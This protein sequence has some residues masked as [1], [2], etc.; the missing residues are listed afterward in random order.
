MD[1]LFV[2]MRNPSPQTDGDAM[3]Q[4]YRLSIG[5]D[6]HHF[7][8][9]LGQSQMK[10]TTDG[11]KCKRSMQYHVTTRS[12]IFVYRIYSAMTSLITLIHTIVQAIHVDYAH[13]P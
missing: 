7:L 3:L 5:R 2:S 11:R 10:I 6:K 8:T 12:D 4:Y 13:N 9:F 1:C